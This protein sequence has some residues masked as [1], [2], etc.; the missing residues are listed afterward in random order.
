M[1]TRRKK[2]TNRNPI[3]E[4][5][6]GNTNYFY[7]STEWD[8][9]R[10]FVLERDNHTCQFFLGNWDDGIHKPYKIEPIEADTVHHIIPSDN[11]VSLSFLAHEIIEDRHKFHFRKR[12][13]PLTEEKW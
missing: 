2:R 13:K 5:M 7:N 6:K 4:L 11:C 8:I 12:K 3:Q 9:L 10:E 1:K